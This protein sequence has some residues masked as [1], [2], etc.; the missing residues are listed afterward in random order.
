MRT[1]LPVGI[2]ESELFGFSTV[3]RMQRMQLLARRL[4]SLGQAT[5]RET[6][7]LMVAAWLVPFLVHLVPWDGAQPLGVHLLPAFW[8]AFVA[9][10]LYGFRI[11]AVVALVVP[12][13][14]LATTGLPT[15]DRMGL[16]TIELVA[17]AGLAALMIRRWP[18]FRFGAPLAWLGARAVAL[19]VQW[20]VPAFAYTRNPVEHYASSVVASL[21]GLGV[22]LALNLA[23][24]SLLPKDREWDAD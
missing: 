4:F 6:I 12:A 23:L 14:N 19:G 2:R 20:S 21:A 3:T 22:M 8:A 1:T 11:G 17:F 16:M 7:V 15:L 5:W 24:V 9:V 10:Y 18:A 13:V